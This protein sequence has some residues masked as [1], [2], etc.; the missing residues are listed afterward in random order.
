MAEKGWYKFGKYV[1]NVDICFTFG[2]NS[3]SRAAVEWKIILSV[4]T[5]SYIFAFKKQN[6]MKDIKG[7]KTEK[8]VIK[9]LLCGYG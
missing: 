1:G 3:Q 4:A 5:F 6:Y 8:L 9:S 2:P 7:R